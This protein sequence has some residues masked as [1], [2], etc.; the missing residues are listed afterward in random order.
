MINKSDRL[1]R[2]KVTLRVGVRDGEGG[3][4]QTKKKE[5]GEM[6]IARWRDIFKVLEQKV[7]EDTKK[8]KRNTEN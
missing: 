4:R 8:R 2:D 1:Q 5:K 3:G 6:D 7:K